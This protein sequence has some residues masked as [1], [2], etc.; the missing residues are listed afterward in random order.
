MCSA[1][2][3]LKNFYFG[4]CLR[5]HPHKAIKLSNKQS[6][7]TESS[8]KYGCRQKFLGKN[9]PSYLAYRLGD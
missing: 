2:L 9:Q 6:K 5:G 7:E 4:V 8:G 1:D 3:N